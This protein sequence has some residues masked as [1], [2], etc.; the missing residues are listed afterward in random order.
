MIFPHTHRATRPDA[1]PVWGRRQG[2]DDDQ[3]SDEDECAEGRDCGGGHEDALRWR[4]TACPFWSGI[5]L[6]RLC[7]Q[8][9]YASNRS[10]VV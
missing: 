3:R 10:G 1:S 9:A 8:V 5:H 4:F 7:K 6:A 2:W